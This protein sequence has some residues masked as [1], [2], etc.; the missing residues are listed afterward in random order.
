MS[1]GAIKSAC[2]GRQTCALDPNNRYYGDPCVY[3]VKYIDIEHVC[4]KK[5]NSKPIKSEPRY[6][7]A[8][9]AS[10][11][12]LKSSVYCLKSSKI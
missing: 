9:Y 4:I 1:E 2:D 11:S 7:L 12:F 10:I 8:D 6:V 5:T 3:T